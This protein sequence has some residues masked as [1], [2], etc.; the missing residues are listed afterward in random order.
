MIPDSRILV[1][2]DVPA[3]IGV[4]RRVL[5]GEGYQILV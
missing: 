1:V 4:L 3:N 5:E 2:D